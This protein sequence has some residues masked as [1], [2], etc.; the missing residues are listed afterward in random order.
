MLR[1]LVAIECTDRGAPSF[2]ALAPSSLPS[3]NLF[4]RAHTSHRLTSLARGSEDAL[5]R[6]ANYEGL[7]AEVVTW[8]GLGHN[9]HVEDPAAVV[10]VL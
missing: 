7:G 9:P 3:I 2:H 8:E 10:A 5:V 6:A 1:A 4:S